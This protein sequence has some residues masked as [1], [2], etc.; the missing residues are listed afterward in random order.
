MAIRVGLFGAGWAAAAVHGPSLRDF[1][2]RRGGIS[3]AGIC[4]IDGAK[5]ERLRREFGF[6]K[7]YASV[8]AMLRDADLDAAI[9]AVSV[10][11]NAPV[12]RACL[13]ARLPVLLEKPPALS[14]RAVRSL[15]E[16]VRKARGKVMVAFNR[17]WTP[18]LVRL[19]ELLDGAGPADS[20]RCDM[21]RV[22]RNDPD[23]ST[24]AIH[25]IDTVRFL[26]D[27]DYEQLT[28]C[29][30]RCGPKGK[31]ASTHIVGTMTGGAV[32]R[33]DI[34]PMAG[35]EMEQYTIHAGGRTLVADLGV[36]R[37]MDELS[38]IAG[39]KRRDVKV[40]TP[41]TAR[42]DMTGFYQEVAAFLEAVKRGGR[43]PGPTVAESVQ[44]VAVMV[45]LGKGRT[46][47]RTA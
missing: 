10:S 9:V 33:F 31:S 27:R 34:T 18:S 28:I 21:R 43:L 39:G 37:H 19:K 42:H 22:K 35:M 30:G 11:Q 8:D 29:Y 6:Q 12:A 20:I 2:R 45:A 4:D 14:V 46:R 40:K 3:L 32:V 36:G 38:V 7:S 41:S 47:Y 17:R 24:T 25:G 13:G 5:A 44:S 1:K 16:S 26:T 23:F 15:A